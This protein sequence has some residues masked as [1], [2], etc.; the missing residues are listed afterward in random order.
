[1]HS[2][3]GFSANFGIHLDVND[4]SVRVYCIPMEYTQDLGQET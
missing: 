4:F 2:F 1:M 3:P